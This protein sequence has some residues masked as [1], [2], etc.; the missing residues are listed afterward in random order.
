MND[1]VR[2]REGQLVWHRVVAERA[3][4]VPTNECVGQ[5]ASSHSLGGGGGGSG[6][7]RTQRTLALAA[8]TT[9]FM[10]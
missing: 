1:T 7:T 4:R 6:Y 2:P 10:F 3:P 9:V 8:I 5:A